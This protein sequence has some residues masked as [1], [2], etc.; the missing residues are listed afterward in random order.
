MFGEVR[1]RE[2]IGGLTGRPAREIVEGVLHR[3]TEF[4]GDGEIEDDLTLIVLK[5]GT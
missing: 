3:V 1:L 4:V 5:V 2:T